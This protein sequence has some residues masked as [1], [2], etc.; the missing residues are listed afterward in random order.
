MN[1]FK[2]KLF[3]LYRILTLYY[4]I[5]ISDIPTFLRYLYTLD[6]MY[7]HDFIRPFVWEDYIFIDDELFESFKDDKPFT[8]KELDSL[9]KYVKE[10]LNQIVK[11]NLVIDYD[12]TCI[13][14]LQYLPD[15]SGEEI[16]YYNEIKENHFLFHYDE[17]K[18]EL[19]QRRIKIIEQ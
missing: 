7:L 1:D 13:E 11:K 12:V 5:D 19:R 14:H 9:S 8:I 6:S 17:Y 10:T 3:Y 16:K 4:K 2:R 15:A 18:S